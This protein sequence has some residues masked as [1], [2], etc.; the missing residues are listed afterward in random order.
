M[1]AGPS[2]DAWGHVHVD[3]GM[4][5]RGIFNRGTVGVVPEVVLCVLEGGDW[6]GDAV[7]VEFIEWED[8]VLIGKEVRGEEAAVDEGDAEPFG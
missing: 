7:E 6:E 1:A 3:V 8:G 2:D 4:A 5:D